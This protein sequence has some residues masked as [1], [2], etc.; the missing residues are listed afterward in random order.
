MPGVREAIEEKNYAEA[1]REIMRVAEALTRET[2]L[3]DELTRTLDQL[4]K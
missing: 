1:E 3:V 2:T 4:P